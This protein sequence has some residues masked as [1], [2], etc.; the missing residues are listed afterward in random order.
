M[1]SYLWT[2]SCDVPYQ[3]VYLCIAQDFLV[4]KNNNN[5]KDSP[6]LRKKGCDTP[7]VYHLWKTRESSCTKE[8]QEVTIPWAWKV[9][10]W[11]LVKDTWLEIKHERVET[12]V[13]SI[14]ERIQAMSWLKCASL[15]PTK[16]PFDILLLF[17]SYQI[18]CKEWAHIPVYECTETL[19]TSVRYTWIPSRLRVL[20]PLKQPCMAFT[21]PPHLHA[22]YLRIC[23]P[24]R[25]QGLLYNKWSI[26]LQLKILRWI[27]TVPLGL[28]I[29]NLG[30]SVFPFLKWGD[31]ELIPV[32]YIKK[33][34]AFPKYSM[35]S[36]TVKLKHKT[37]WE[38]MPSVHFIT[39]T[40]PL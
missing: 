17:E 1:K 8:E 23:F 22:V 3:Q 15:T 30:T 4:F 11:K 7:G 18:Q 35:K 28:T 16:H 29:Y 26:A 25:S 39:D 32:R 31:I 5:R 24:L 12:T 33:H 38:K 13:R 14:I 10:E 40:T 21:C 37:L 19:R 36:I 20:F 9:R 34:L 6:L 27:P 2:R